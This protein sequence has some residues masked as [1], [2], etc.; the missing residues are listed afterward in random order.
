MK[1]EAWIFGGIGIF[2]MVIT[3]IYW[4]LSKDP[5]GTAALSLTLGLC[6]LVA[7][8]LYYTGKRLPERPEDRKSA[9]VHEGA[10]ELGFFS[11]HSVWPLYLGA[12]VALAAASV[13]IGWWLFIIAAGLVAIAVCFYV[14]EYYR[15]V[16]AG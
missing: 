2:F 3:P 4:F 11:P 10:G 12:S 9:E 14:F 6:L 16:Y 15:G 8:Y 5:T 13:A 1:V 7:F